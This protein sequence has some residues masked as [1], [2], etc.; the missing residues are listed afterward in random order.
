M[1]TSGAIAR[2]MRALE[3]S[4]RPSAIDEMQAASAVGQGGLF[5][6]YEERLAGDE[7]RA[8]QVL[9]TA[10]DLQLR[11]HYLNARQTLRRLLAWRIVPVVNE[12]DTTA[13]DEITFG[14]N[15]F[16]A[17]QVAIM[18]E[19]RLLVLLTDQAGLYTKDPRRHDDAELV[20][21]VTD[22]SQLAGYEIG[23]HT[24]PF[25]LGGMRSKVGR[26]DDGGRLGHRRRDLRRDRRRDPAG[27]GRRRGRAAPA[28]RRIPSAPR[29]SSSGCATPSRAT[30]R[31]ASTTAPPVSCARAAAACCR[32]ASPRS[33]ASSRPATPSTSPPTARRSAR[34]SSTT[35]PASC[36][37]SRACG[38]RRSASCSRTPPRRPCTATTSC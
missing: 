33:R 24:S 30:G 34:G 7:V 5:R 35:R 10:S 4:R 6:A 38:P 8:A 31:C 17:A 18:L 25:G 19:A 1:V 37:G 16:L 13:T 15:D 2:G 27:C 28:S 20:S 36:A 29:A 3:M 12:N 32:S 21:E 26:G 23:E 14:D 11:T 22:E 9:L